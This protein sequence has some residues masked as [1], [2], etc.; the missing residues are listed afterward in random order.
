M[1]ETK[2]APV[3][4]IVIPFLEGVRM[5]VRTELL[6]ETDALLQQLRQIR[7]GEQRPTLRQCVELLHHVNRL[8][9][10]S[11]PRGAGEELAMQGQTDPFHL[12]DALIQLQ[13]IYASE[14]VTRPVVAD[15]PPAPSLEPPAPLEEEI[16]RWLDAQKGFTGFSTPSGWIIAACPGHPEHPQMTAC[17]QRLYALFGADLG[18]LAADLYFAP[19]RWLPRYYEQHPEYSVHMAAILNACIVAYAPLDIL[20]RIEARI[21]YIRS[22]MA[23]PLLHYSGERAEISSFFL[24]P[25]R[26]WISDEMMHFINSLCYPSPFSGR[27]QQLRHL[28]VWPAWLPGSLQACLNVLLA[29]P[30][31]PQ[32][33]G[34]AMKLQREDY[35]ERDVVYG[36]SRHHT[37][38]GL[39]E[40]SIRE[41][42]VLLFRFGAL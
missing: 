33:C 6:G 12:L 22:Y 40:P 30:L 18:W 32:S 31:T 24:E 25:P 41:A 1:V 20:E 26:A 13:S 17:L 35:W 16:V 5:Y 37:L 8:W 2:L 27:L 11:R 36:G 19:Q 3:M 7:A 10:V 15:E 4:D 21:T 23:D 34:L 14:V 9:N 38:S 39:V 28:R 29:L 42:L